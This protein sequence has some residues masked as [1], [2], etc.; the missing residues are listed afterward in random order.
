MCFLG[1]GATNSGAFHESLNLAS[2]FDLP[3]V[4][5]IENN[6][7]AMGTSVARSSAFGGCLAKRAE[8]YDIEWDHFTD[9]DPYEIRARMH[10]ALQR[11]RKECRPSVV[12]ITTYRYY[13]FSVADAN[14]K[15]YRSPEEI[16]ERRANDPLTGWKNHLI[17]EGWLNEAGFDEIDQSANSEALAA[18]Q[19]AEEGQAPGIWNLRQSVYWE[20]DHG[21]DSSLIGRHFFDPA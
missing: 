11:A 2:L 16:E 9:A 15:R 10:T 1:D 6:G 17:E 7:Y 19:E 3:V 18:A 4:Y 5:V 14:H 12:E 8:G 20:S 21:T 13:G